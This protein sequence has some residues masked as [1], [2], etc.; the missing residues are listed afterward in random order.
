MGSPVLVEREGSIARLVLNRPDA[1]NA[2]DVG[3]ADALARTAA[4][5]AD[6]P[7]VRCVMLTGAGRMFCVG[8]DIDGFSAAGDN[9]GAYLQ[10]L[11]DRVHDAVKRL[12]SMAKPLLVV[13][14]GPA[15]GAGLSLAALGDVVLAGSSAH[16]TA[17]Y[18]GIGLTA[19][20]G[21][22]WLLPRLIGLRR[23]QEMILTNARMSAVDAAAHGL[24]TR[25]VAD[26]V[27][28]AEGKVIAAKLS[29]APTAALGA[30]RELL[31]DGAT[32][33]F[34]DHLDREAA[35]IAAAASG[36]EAREGIAAF[37]GRRKPDFG[38]TPRT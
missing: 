33:T 5:V 15:A 2:I 14:N 38:K 24:V 37:L 16:F 26:E 29:A 23:A 6:D 7:S 8:G 1:G 18:S 13:V 22:S 28:C 31:L 17:A 27:L 34:S 35:V 20:G 21:M 3:L 32:A 19:D 10:A 9:A 30:V 4:E 36:A 12:A 11:A 25:T